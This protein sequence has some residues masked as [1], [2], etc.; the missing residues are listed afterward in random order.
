MIATRAARVNRA[1]ALGSARLRRLP[2]LRGFVVGSSRL[3]PARA[4][5]GFFLFPERRAGLEII[6]DELASGK[7]F[8]AVRSGDDDEHDLVGGLQLADAVN[9]E[10]FHYVPAGLRLG[11]DFF[12]GLLGHAGI[13]FESHLRHRGAVVGVAAYPDKARHRADLRVAASERRD[14]GA[15]VEVL[16]LDTHRHRQPPVTGGKNAISSPGF[17]GVVGCAISWLTATR[18]ARPCASAA[19]QARPRAIRSARKPA[20]LDVA[21][22]ISR[23]S[24]ALPN[25]SRRLARSTTLIFIDTA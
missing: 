1:G 18:S 11:D 14:L 25:C 4:L 24:P 6:H 12:E 3:D 15:R 13:V 9:H 22:A 16:R 8:A 21:G 23:S 5:R 20:T 2:A 7:G 19:C 10:H 17:T